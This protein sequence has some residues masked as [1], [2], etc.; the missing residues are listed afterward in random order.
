MANRVKQNE[1]FFRDAI[2]KKHKIMKVTENVI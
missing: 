1:Q 2:A